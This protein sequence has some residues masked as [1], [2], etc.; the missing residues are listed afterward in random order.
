MIYSR[1]ETLRFIVCAMSQG[2]LLTR[3]DLAGMI[4]S[5]LLS[6]LLAKAIVKSPVPRPC[7]AVRIMAAVLETGIGAGFYIRV[8]Y[9]AE[10]QPAAL[11]NPGLILLTVILSTAGYFFLMPVMGGLFTSSGADKKHTVLAYNKWH[12][13][14]YCFFCSSI[15]VTCC[16]ECS[17]LYP[18]DSWVD[19]NCFLTV[20][21]SL[22]KG[23][24]PYRDLIEQKGPM[25]YFLYGAA[26]LIEPT[27]FLGVYI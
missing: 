22:V 20:G 18:I 24:V 7:T 14:L 21:K 1:K 2:I 17:F 27:S 3:M 15:C 25:L 23:L 5:A 10:S 4:L 11:I 13:L 6:G 16:S 19:A 12:L 9:A 26:A 8:I